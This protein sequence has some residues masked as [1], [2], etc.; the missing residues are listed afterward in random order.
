[1]K[2]IFRIVFILNLVKFKAQNTEIVKP[3]EHN[4][5]RVYIELGMIQPLGQFKKQMDNSL[6]YGLWFRTELK[7]Q[8][9]MDIGFNFWIPKN[10]QPIEIKHNGTINSYESS[11]FN[12]SMGGRLAKVFKLSQN[13]STEWISGFGITIFQYKVPNTI[14]FTEDEE[15]HKNIL[16][17]LYLEQGLKL[18]YKNIG[19]QVHYHY[20]PIELV[21]TYV[22][23]DFGTSYLTFGILYR[24]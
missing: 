10:A 16:L 18:N 1:M 17:P 4:Y 14:H 2:N 11:D 13:I 5:E 24:Q 22:K 6:H 23:T 20:M 15:N 19:L 3:K 12:L 21:N 9:F 8:N 7:H